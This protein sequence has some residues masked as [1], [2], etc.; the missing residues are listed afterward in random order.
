[1]ALVAFSW[2]LQGGFQ[3]AVGDIVS[4][5]PLREGLKL[6]HQVGILAGHTYVFLQDYWPREMWS[7]TGKGEIRTPGFV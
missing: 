5:L 6:T 7:T 2:L 1:M 3:A 4:A